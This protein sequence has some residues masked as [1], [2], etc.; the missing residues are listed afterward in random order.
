[1]TRKGKAKKQRDEEEEIEKKP[2][3]AFF[4]YTSFKREKLISW[5]GEIYI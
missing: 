5:S 3:S 2:N 4:L 1:M